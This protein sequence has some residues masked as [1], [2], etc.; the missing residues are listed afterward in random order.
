[1]AL[2]QNTNAFG[3]SR[4]IRAVLVEGCAPVRAGIRAVLERASDIE[5]CAE[6]AQAWTARELVRTHRPDVVAMNREIGADDGLELARALVTAW[7]VLQIVMY[8]DQDELLFV[9]EAI[10]SGVRALVN[11]VQGPAVLADAIR[12]VAAGEYYFAA[13]TWHYLLGP[14]SEMETGSAVSCEGQGGMPRAEVAPGIHAQMR[15]DRMSPTRRNG[16]NGGGHGG[17]GT[18]ENAQ[19]VL[20]K[21]WPLALDRKTVVI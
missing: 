15:C 21:D 20:G 13:E 18:P 5:L 11:D 12:S 8:T 9:D 17:P 2:E 7:P 4:K 6:T 3:G 10:V 19:G 14:S 16:R 1:M